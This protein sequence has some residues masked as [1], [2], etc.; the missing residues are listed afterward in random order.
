MLAHFSSMDD[1]KT[2]A[3]ADSYLERII[4]QSLDDL[5]SGIDVADSKYEV[6]KD[7]LRK[8]VRQKIGRQE[9]LLRLHR[10][11][12]TGRIDSLSSRPMPL[13]GVAIQKFSDWQRSMTSFGDSLRDEWDSALLCAGKT[14]HSHR[15]LDA[16]ALSQID[17]RNRYARDA[18][19][20]ERVIYIT[21]D[22][23]VILAARKIAGEREGESFAF[24]YVRHPM[25]FLDE[26]GL[27]IND[28]QDESGAS[29]IDWMDVLLA[30]SSDLRYKPDD[31]AAGEIRERWRKLSLVQEDQLFLKLG[32]DDLV[33]FA[34][35]EVELVGLDEAAVRLQDKAD[36]GE[37]AAWR[38]CFDIAIDFALRRDPVDVQQVLRSAPPICFE[39]WPNAGLAVERFKFWG[40][41][42]V[43]S[44]KEFEDAKA[45][46]EDGE[47]QSGYAYYLAAASFFA[48]RGDW[49]P[50]AALSAFSRSVSLR[51]GKKLSDGSNGR[52]ASYLEAVSRRHLARS[53][54]DLKLPS[55]RLE[56]CRSILKEEE[57][58]WI[59]PMKIVPERFDLEKLDIKQVTLFFHWLREVSPKKL[60]TEFRELFSEYMDLW[61][62]NLVPQVDKQLTEG[63][64]DFHL[65]SEAHVLVQTEVRTI[66]SSLSL[67]TGD[68]ISRDA[69][70]AADVEAL[71]GRL[72]VLRRWNAHQVA[73]SDDH[74]AQ[75]SSVLAQLS[76]FVASAL[77]DEAYGRSANRA[78]LFEG[79]QIL[80]KRGL[81]PLVLYPYDARRF[82]AMQS[83]LRRN[84]KRVHG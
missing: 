77:V 34:Q 62:V 72:V 53:L 73:A 19:S 18:G 83:I 10:M 82:K 64:A 61:R 43:P 37:A 39:G 63:N 75:D 5:V 30:D 46:L 71:L 27:A 29:L 17:L 9:G 25:A 36:D 56:E 84:M 13:H 79:Q 20:S 59:G 81:R 55:A 48:A 69:L 26:I 1:P 33:R 45:Q 50:A 35:S 38:G 23:H 49:V 57:R 54:F 32:L 78:A 21:A 41:K 22:A 12:R 42:G 47:D 70:P 2:I 51:P 65:G 68:A 8:L 44:R 31:V 7:A 4:N 60:A 76:V 3:L 6:L 15:T 40:A 52:E 66:V 14:S 80:R 28:G 24:S 58:A 16:A 74:P 67:L 11:L